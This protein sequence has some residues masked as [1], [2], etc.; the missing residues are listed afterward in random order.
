MVQKLQTEIRRTICELNV[1]RSKQRKIT[2]QHDGKYFYF[3]TTLY[4]AEHSRI[5][6]LLEYLGQ[7]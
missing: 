2:M 5:M 1:L 6:G 4:C 7:Q 3:Y